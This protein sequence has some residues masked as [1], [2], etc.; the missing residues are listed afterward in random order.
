MPSLGRCSLLPLTSLKALILPV[1]SVYSIS[2]NNFLTDFKCF[3]SS[4]LIIALQQHAVVVMV[5]LLFSCN[6]GGKVSLFQSPFLR[7]K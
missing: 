2:S 4:F 1:C 3:D 6:W 5:E 7:W